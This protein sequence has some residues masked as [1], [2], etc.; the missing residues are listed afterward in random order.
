MS[1][2]RRD[3]SDDLSIAAERAQS[4]RAVA[5]AAAVGRAVDGWYN[6]WNRHQADAHWNALDRYAAAASHQLDLLV[7]YTAGDGFS[8]RQAA[9]TAIQT[10]TQLDM[11][12]TAGA[13]ALSLLVSWALGRRILRP[14][15]LASSI[16]ERI[17]GGALDVEIPEASGD[18]LGRL[19]G[20][21][22]VMRDS[23]SRMMAREVEQRRSAQARLM[24][25]IE[26][27]REGVILVNAEGRVVVSNTQN[28]EFF[29]DFA[30]LLQPGLLSRTSWWR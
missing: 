27:S 15:S 26:S 20:P 30:Q 10:N 5:A 2:F 12:L 24:D 7:N 29:Q 3:L 1:R 8:F 14:V 19:L 9:L 4:D 16:A 18:E 23:I 25:A 11:M 22:A 13:I 17:A 21:M 28:I 6:D